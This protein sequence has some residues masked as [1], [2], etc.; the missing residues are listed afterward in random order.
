M[1]RTHVAMAV[2]AACSVWGLLACSG[3]G[4]SATPAGMT[5]SGVITGFGSVYVNGIEY[6]TAG[7]SVYMDDVPGDE[8]QLQPGMLVT[9]HG[10][11]SADG[12]TGTADSITYA[13]VVEGVVLA[14]SLSNGSGTL[15]VMGQAVQ[16]NELTLFESDV[17]GIT[18][19]TIPLNCIAE[20]SGYT[21]GG[22]T[23]YA[24]RIEI[25]QAGL[26]P[27]DVLEV[28]GT[29]AGLNAVTFRIGNLIV[30]YSGAAR[31]P[32]NLADGLY[33]E[34]KGDAAPTDNGD[35]THTFAATDVEMEDDGDIGIGGSEGD[36][37]QMQGVVM[38][39]DVP[40]GTIGVN[41][42][43]MDVRADAM[44]DGLTLADLTVGTFIRLEA[45]FTG[46]QWLVKEI[47]VGRSSDVEIKSIIEAV[48]LTAGT[49]TVMGRDIV[50]GAGTLLNDNVSVAPEH[51]FDITD[52]Q[53]GD[54]VEAE[55]AIGGAGQWEAIKL[56]REDPGAGVVLEAK[57]T[58]E[59]PVQVAG[60]DVAGLAGL[61]ITPALDMTL[62]ISGTWD[63]S[64]F[65]ASAATVY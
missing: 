37:L 1:K 51:Y 57:V 12:V 10:S 34:V 36:D 13:D 47:E 25:K 35:G 39:I 28:K 48:D 24:S 30:D 15:N 32:G 5:I 52:L 9:L 21:D 17:P 26:L 44:R 2:L 58:S 14:V 56:T 18:L 43:L 8:L 53:I 64:T 46:A 23:I 41:G 4:S 22:G 61:G 6:D 16:V 29:V 59:M 42:Q 54:R 60:I 7:A 33:V 40:A 49:I 27:G 31:V 20:I 11:N 55:V 38:A 50:I 63:G 45:E 19:D 62:E 3:G 65:T